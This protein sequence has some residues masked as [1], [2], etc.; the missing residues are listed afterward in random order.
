MFLDF[1]DRNMYRVFYN[2]AQKCVKVEIGYNEE[3]FRSY[4]VSH[5]ECDDWVRHYIA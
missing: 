3:H 1:Y 5:H 2:P 4:S